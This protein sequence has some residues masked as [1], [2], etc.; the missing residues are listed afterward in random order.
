M[1]IEE[2]IKKY[3]D[4]DIFDTIKL[5]EYLKIHE[6]IGKEIFKYVLKK[7]S[8]QMEYKN[9]KKFTMQIRNQMYEDGFGFEPISRESF[10]KRIPF[11][12]FINK[13][14]DYIFAG[15]LSDVITGY[16][17]DDRS[18]IN[19]DLESIY[20]TLEYMFYD[21]KIDLKML[22]SYV[23][24][25][26]GSSKN[27][28]IFDKWVNYLK[29]TNDNP[30]RELYP[31]NILYSYNIALIEHGF[32][33]ILYEHCYTGFNEDYIRIKDT[34]SIR[35]EFPID[36]LTNQVIKEWILVWIEDEEYIKTKRFAD[37]NCKSL[38]VELEIGL[39]PNTKIY[40]PN[41]YLDDEEKEMNKTQNF[42]LWSPIYAGP[43]AMVFDYTELK[44]AREN[45]KK[46][47]QQVADACGVKIRTYQYWESGK[48]NPDALSLVR[49]MNYLDIESVQRM[50][51]RYPIEDYGFHKF[52]SGMSL[53]HFTDNH[54]NENDD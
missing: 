9:G 44:F 3:I 54:I 20:K 1:K 19:D 30:T 24:L 27:Y 11:Y 45:C 31:K 29:L 39:G 12:F 50:V 52:S 48:N 26:C 40:L 15:N 7:D 4:S 6:T 49:I 8:Y 28:N 25:Q 21:L 33:P 37:E 18:L 34:I 36:P 51:K 17:E 14:C 43:L 23:A 53:D 5:S 32:S 41:L 10:I 16:Y 2:Q 46:T 47:Q 13:K 42:N 22:F 38:E 35:G